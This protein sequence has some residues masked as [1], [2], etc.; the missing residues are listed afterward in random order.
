MPG[1]VLRTRD[2]VIKVSYFSCYHMISYHIISHSNRERQ[3][4]DKHNGDKYF[5]VVIIALK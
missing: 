1:T 3:M 5:Q 4:K 2:I